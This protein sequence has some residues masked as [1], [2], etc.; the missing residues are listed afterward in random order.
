MKTIAFAR[1]LFLRPHDA[2][3]VR[4]ITITGAGREPEIIGDWSYLASIVWAC[5]NLQ[6]LLIAGL[7][8]V[9]LSS[10]HAGRTHR[11][12]FSTMLHADLLP[13]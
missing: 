6:D 11:L 2:L 8:D 7:C 5:S 3:A 4:S 10:L 1:V 9:N 12:G 13:V